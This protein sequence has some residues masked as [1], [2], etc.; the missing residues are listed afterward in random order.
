MTSG[1]SKRM[2]DGKW[3]EPKNIG[4]P[5]NT[6]DREEKAYFDVAT[7]WLFFSSDGHGGKGGMDIFKVKRI[8]PDKWGDVIPVDAVNSEGNDSYFT[9]SENSDYAYFSSDV[10][11]KNQIYMVPL[12]EIFTPQ[13]IA[14]RDKFYKSNMPPAVPAVGDM[15]IVF[16]KKFCAAGPATC[17]PCAA[18]AI[19]QPNIA[20]IIYFQLGKADL[21]AEAEKTASAW[22]KYLKDNPSRKIK[23]GG[24]ADTVGDDTYNLILSKKRADA[25]KALLIKDGAKTGAAASGLFWRFAARGSQR[26]QGR[27]CQE[28]QSGIK[29]G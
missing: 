9:L 14:A 3:S 12:T 22:A 26:S 7:G 21:N 16:K 6:P 8:G 25:V 2:A 20:S 4:A 29:G 28:P 17:P 11:G 1:I 15:A 27:R 10:S 19:E 13:E 24:H 5:V 18:A 23:I